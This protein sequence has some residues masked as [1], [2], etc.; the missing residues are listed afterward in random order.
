VR[1]RM[2]DADLASPSPCGWPAASATAHRFPPAEESGLVAK[3][4][5][6]DKRY[7][8]IVHGCRLYALESVWHFSRLT[9]IAEMSC[10]V[11]RGRSLRM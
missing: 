4:C 11:A 3:H 5:A 1:P 6:G 10:S 8:V 9:L 7:E 2:S